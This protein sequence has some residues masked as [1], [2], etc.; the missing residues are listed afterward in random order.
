MSKK[1]SD[2]EVKADDEKK[3][4]FC[5]KCGADVNEY[6]IEASEEEKKE[7]LRCILANRRYTKKYSLFN[8]TLSLEFSL[9]S[10]KDSHTMGQHLEKLD[11]SDRVKSIADAIKIK[12][13]YYC[14]SFNTQSFEVPLPD[15]SWEDLY[16]QRFGEMSEDIPIMIAKVMMQFIK[17]TE[18]LSTEAL[19]ESFW[20]GAGLA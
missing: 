2:A 19:D 3:E 12:T 16:N 8:N 11:V 14:K 17:L 7:Y 13:L 6:K 18:I 1:R 15:E 10:N 4:K 20:E 5:P 9:L